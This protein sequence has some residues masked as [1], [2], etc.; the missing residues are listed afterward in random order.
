MKRLILVL[1]TAGLF[2][3]CECDDEYRAG[4]YRPEV[5]FCWENHD[6]EE[7]TCHRRTYR[8]EPTMYAENV[9]VRVYKGPV[10]YYNCRG[11]V[12]CRGPVKCR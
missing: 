6:R 1:C 2:T 11:P 5:R 7:D 4:Y 9:Y 8:C 3:A 12:D 10:Y